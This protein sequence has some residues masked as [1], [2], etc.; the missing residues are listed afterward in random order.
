MSERALAT[1]RRIAAIK[2]IP[3]ADKI[4]LAIVDGWQVVVKKGEYQ[5]GE[6]AVYCEVDSWIPHSLAPFLT[7]SGHLPKIYQGIEGQRLKTIK[8][9]GELSQG[10]LLPFEVMNYEQDGQRYESLADEGCDVT[11]ILGIVKWEKEIP[12]CMVGRSRGNFPSLI[13]KTD[14]ERIQNLKRIWEDNYRYKT[15]FV[16]EKLHGSSM[17]CY[18][19]QEGVFHVCSRNVDLIETEDNVYWQVASKLKIEEKMRDHAAVYPGVFGLAIQGELCGPGINGNQYGLTEP[20]FFM[21]GA[22]HDK[23]GRWDAKDAYSLSQQFELKHVP[24]VYDS[25]LSTNTVVEALLVMAEGKSR[26]N[27]SEREGLVF[28]NVDNPNEHFKCV[29]NKWCLEGGEDQ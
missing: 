19:D 8:L 15:W 24:V 25:F 17:T 29:S 23:H 20:D 9:R 18:L 13:P 28:V 11:E 12:A 7:K 2:E 26:I 5:A 16:T 3:G 1:I 22:V 14:Q 6:I 27:G 10:L 4:E 21:F